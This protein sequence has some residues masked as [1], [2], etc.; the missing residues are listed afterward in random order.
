MANHS[1]DIYKNMSFLLANGIHL[2][3]ILCFMGIDNIYVY[4]AGEMG[5]L[6]LYDLSGSNKVVAV[7]DR[8]VRTDMSICIYK[9]KKTESKIITYEYPLYHP[10][11]IPNDKKYILITPASMYVEITSDLENRGITKCRFISLNLLLYYGMLYRKSWQKNQNS[12]QYLP[13]KQFLIT[14]AQFKNKG[15]QAMLFTTICELR[16]RFRDAVVWCC[17]NIYDKRDI[18][19]SEQYNLILLLDGI[20]KDST[21]YELLPHLDGIID[22]SGYALTSRECVNATEREMHYVRMARS[23]QVP[24]YFMPQSFGPF[25]YN[26]E[27]L[28]EIKELLSYAKIIYAREWESYN[29][30][31]NECNLSNIRHS[32]DLVLQNRSINPEYIYTCVKK[33]IEFSLPTRANV[34]LIPNIQNYKNGNFKEV[35]ETYRKVITKLTSFEKDVYIIAHSDDEQ[36]C[37]DIYKE[38]ANNTKVHLYERELDCVEFAEFIEHFQYI[39][40]SR[41]HAIV[42]AYK[43][44]IPCMVIGWAEKYRELLQIFGQAQYLF[45]V[46]SSI[47]I[48]KVEDTLEMM[49]ASYKAERK[50]IRDILS[51]VQ[52]E[53][54]FDILKNN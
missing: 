15:S 49:N 33:K 18:D 22:V 44:G 6:T 5:K 35:E 1:L 20:N 51:D 48:K 52:K 25:N 47:D 30:L 43:K 17:P 53:N 24:I 16:K 40:A 37:K 8:S 3:D 42:Q 27:K 50:S 54:C 21:L 11:K 38:F 39:I 31:V 23:C 19:T 28:K 32:N 2:S 13:E 45:D 14:G 4:G 36:V 26:E 12:Y 29:L 9:T 46:R 10:D 41:Y 34:A 7:F